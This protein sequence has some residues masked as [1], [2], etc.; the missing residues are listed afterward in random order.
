MRTS[1]L[2]LSI[3]FSSVV[4]SQTAAAEDS[5][6]VKNKLMIENLKNR[7]NAIDNNT[8]DLLGFQKQLEALRKEVA[9]QNNSI[10]K[11]LGI[12]NELKQYANNSSMEQAPKSTLRINSNIDKLDLNSMSDNNYNAL[13]KLDVDLQQYLSTCN[14]SPLFYKPYQVELN[15]NELTDLNKVIKQFE[16]K[17]LQKII[18]KGHADRSGTEDGNVVLSKQRA[19]MLKNYLI[20]I[21]DKIKKEDIEIEWHGSSLPIKDLSA[22]NQ[23]LNRRTEI[24]IK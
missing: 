7:I 2:I 8:N 11:L 6:I 13:K 23:G 10:N 16:S 17:P 21:S 3:C 24:L 5:T 19:E 12:I 15:F 18:I 4:Y 9:R 1:I 20:S 22:T 14:C